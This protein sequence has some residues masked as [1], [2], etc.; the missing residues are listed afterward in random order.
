MPQSLRLVQLPSKGKRHVRFQD[1][2]RTY[3]STH[4]Q[5]LWKFCDRHGANLEEWKSNCACCSKRYQVDQAVVHQQVANRKDCRLY[6]KS[7]H[8]TC[9]LLPLILSPYSVFLSPLILGS[10]APSLQVWSWNIGWTVAQ[11][12]CKLEEHKGD[13]GT[14][15]GPSLGHYCAH[16]SI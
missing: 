6:M 11:R 5:N 14:E 13:D 10:A 2:W 1:K 16:Y 7:K 12:T 3:T 9:S 15:E 4:T 8:K